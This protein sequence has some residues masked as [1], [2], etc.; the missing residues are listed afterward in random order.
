MSAFYCNNSV[1]AKCVTAIMSYAGTFGDF[2]MNERRET[3]GQK[4]GKALRE[5]NVEAL[6]Q[7]YPGR[8]SEDELN[9]SFEFSDEEYLRLRD[10]HPAVLMKAIDCLGY[11]CAEGNVP[12]TNP[13]FRQLEEVGLLIENRK[14][15]L[16]GTPEYG[17]APWGD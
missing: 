7:R 6:K 12:D 8:L 11:Q 4:I 13:L 14:G 17:R 5:M 15:P 1:I 2:Y 9:T 16:R 3:L 10:E